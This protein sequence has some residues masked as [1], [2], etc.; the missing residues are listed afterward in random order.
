[1]I[2]CSYRLI[3]L[4]TLANDLPN[5]IRATFLR[6]C[7]CCTHSSHVLYICYSHVFVTIV[8]DIPL[9]HDGSALSIRLTEIGM[10]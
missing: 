6:E 5:I 3:M 8:L 9:M 7:W 10:P 4:G 2:H 1:M